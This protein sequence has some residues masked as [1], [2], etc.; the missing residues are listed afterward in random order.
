VAVDSRAVALGCEETVVCVLGTAQSNVCYTVAC[1]GEDAAS[2]RDGVGAASKARAAAFE[3]WEAG[4]GDGCT[5]VRKVTDAPSEECVAG[6]VI[7]FVEMVI[8]WTE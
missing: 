6:S 7:A 4:I 3:E 2:G 1:M 5:V 8:R